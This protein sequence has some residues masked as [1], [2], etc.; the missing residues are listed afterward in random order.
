MPGE[1]SEKIQVSEKF[2]EKVSNTA[3]ALEGLG[4]S[5]AFSASAVEKPLSE[6][7]EVVKPTFDG[8]Q[9]ANSEKTEVLGENA[10]GNAGDKPAGTENQ[11][12][13]SANTDQGQQN[14]EKV[15]EGEEGEVTLD[16]PIFGGKKT[17]GD[18]KD[19]DKDADPVTNF[20]SIED[21]DK[22]AKANG[23][24]DVKSLAVKLPDM[25]KAAQQLE[26]VSKA[27]TNYEAIFEHMPPELFESIRKF[28][29]GE[30]WRAH[31]ASSE[32]ID[33][34]ADFTK[35]DSSK[36]V[37]KYYPNKISKD[38]W[39]E[40]NDKD[41]NAEVKTKVGEYLS[42]AKDKYALDQEKFKAHKEKIDRTASTAM[43]ARTKSLQAS[44][45]NVIK[46]FE[47]SNLTI[48][49][50]YVGS[51]DKD[52]S[53]DRTILS[54]FKNDD[55]TLKPDAHQRLAMAKDGFGLVTQYQK[56]IEKRAVSKERADVL[57]RT[58]TGS[59]AMKKSGDNAGS[60]SVKNSEKKVR[61]Y[62][63]SILPTGDEQVFK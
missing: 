10:Q 30:D 63:N 9:Q 27:K 14:A 18:K 13:Q 1:N 45:E 2:A 12:Q 11:Q 6:R 47:S 62:V 60:D 52:L 32:P 35:H 46:V 39:D 28:S 59:Q 44:K 29:I 57:D 37:E 4:Q 53:N 54:Y 38:D 36:M 21:V 23:F 5:D 17:I 34:E 25:I 41:G 19:A 15:A 55:G 61:D 31:I 48:D 43:E 26:E 16:S 7:I 49:E 8:N 42:L 3:A 56:Q 50:K 22:F 51:L 24:D 20:E 58:A 33:F 40:Y